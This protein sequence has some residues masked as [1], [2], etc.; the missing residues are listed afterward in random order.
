MCIITYVIIGKRS[1]RLTRQQLYEP[2]VKG[3]VILFTQQD[4]NLVP[5]KI[6]KSWLLF[7]GHGHK[8]ICASNKKLH[9][10]KHCEGR[11]SQLQNIF[12]FIIC[13]FVNSSRFTRPFS[14]VQVVEVCIR[15]TSCRRTIDVLLKRRQKFVRSKSEFCV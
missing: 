15:S 2:Y 13:Y 10:Q 7:S 6:W 12:T 1:K 4:L 5:P 3:I 8:K 11:E 9:V 14:S